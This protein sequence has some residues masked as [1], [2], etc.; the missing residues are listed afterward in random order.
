MMQT[1]NFCIPFILLSLMMETDSNFHIPFTLFLMMQT[2]SSLRIP[3]TLISFIMQ[4]VSNFR[5]PFTLL[6]LM[7]QTDSNIRIQFILYS[8][9][10]FLHYNVFIRILYC[11]NKTFLHIYFISLHVHL[12][13]SFNLHFSSLFSLTACVPVSEADREEHLKESCLFY[14][15]RE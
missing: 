14:E 4:T 10:F 6:F 2:V 1:A 7:M 15:R 11:I 8:F 9:N 5:I 12:R 3:F 13:I